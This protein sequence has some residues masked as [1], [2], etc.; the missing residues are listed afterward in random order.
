MGNNR[1][2][3]MVLGTIIAGIGMVAFAGGNMIAPEPTGIV[4]MIVGAIL[5]VGGMAWIFWGGD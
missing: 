5:M 1:P 4:S 2:A 3:W